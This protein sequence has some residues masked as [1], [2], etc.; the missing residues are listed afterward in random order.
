MSKPIRFIERETGIEVL[1]ESFFVWEGDRCGK[2]CAVQYPSGRKYGRSDTE[3]AKDFD[4][5]TPQEVF[6][7]GFGGV[8]DRPTKL[9]RES[10][11]V[12]TEIT[13]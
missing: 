1:V 13:L 7:E 6:I 8:D 3:L 2:V 9:Q 10:T 11:A 5:V 4:I 12:T